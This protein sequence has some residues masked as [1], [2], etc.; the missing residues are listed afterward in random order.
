VSVLASPPHLILA[1]PAVRTTLSK[2]C[3]NQW[4]LSELPRHE[5]GEGRPTET[6]C[7]AGVAGFE[8]RRE[9]GKE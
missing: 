9:T 6:D 7:V 3:Q 2:K 1:R 8:V 4:I 5:N